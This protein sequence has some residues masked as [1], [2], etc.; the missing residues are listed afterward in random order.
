[1]QK[2]RKHGKHRKTIEKLPPSSAFQF[3]LHVLRRPPGKASRLHQRRREKVGGARHRHVRR[4]A[5]CTRGLAKQHDSRLQ[6]KATGKKVA[7]LWRFMVISW[8]FYDILGVFGDD[9]MVI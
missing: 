2:H 1:M 6:R 4:D 3:Q 9:L 8:I 7:M 5:A